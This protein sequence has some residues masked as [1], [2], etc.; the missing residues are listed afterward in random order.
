LDYV[1]KRGLKNNRSPVADLGFYVGGGTKIIF[2][3]NKSWRAKKNYQKDHQNFDKTLHLSKKFTSKLTRAEREKNFFTI[4][5]TF[6]W[7]FLQ[8]I[9]KITK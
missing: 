8:N 4:F 7:I 5:Q 9:Q 2:L 1:E 3:E 6:E